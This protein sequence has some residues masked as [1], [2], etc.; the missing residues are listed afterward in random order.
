[1]DVTNTKGDWRE[2]TSDELL[3][4]KRCLI[5]HAGQPMKE[6]EPLQLT[7]GV[8]SGAETKLALHGLRARGW[9]EAVTKSWG[10]RIL[11][12]PIQRLPDLY[13]MLLEQ[14]TMNVV[15]T[16]YPVA[17]HEAITGLEAELLHT[18]SRIAVQGVPLT[19]KGTIHKRS[20]QK[21]NE[22]T[23][24]H[25]ED[26]V[27]LGL[28]YAHSDLYPVQT[29]IMMDLLLSLG[30][31]VKEAVSFRIQEAELAAWIQL[32]AW[33]MRKHI[34]N[35]LMER[36][37]KAEA[38]MQHFRYMLCAASR[39][40]GA[41][42]W[43][44]VKS[45][46]QWMLQVGL[47]SQERLNGAGSQ[48]SAPME[49]SA[50]P[51]SS[52]AFEDE[53]KGWLKALTAFGMGDWGLNALGELCFRWNISPL[54][55]LRQ[56][57]DEKEA[58]NQER[59]T[60]YIQPDFEILVPPEVAY[61]V[62]WRLECCCERVTGDR[63]AIYRIT[64]ESVTE[65]IELGMEAQAIFAL[66]DK[67]SRTGVPDHVRVALEQWA[68]DV[69]RTAFATVTLLRCGTHEDADTVA[70]HPGLEGLLERIGERD[71]IIPGHSTAKI[72]KTLAAIGLSPRREP[73]GVDEPIHRYP[74][75]D[76]TDHTSSG[77]PDSEIRP[78]EM[79]VNNDTAGSIFSQEGRAGLVYTGRTLHFYEREH[80]PPDPLDY[81]PESSAVP[82]SWT[83]EWRSYHVSTARQLI[84]QAIRW[85]T[86]VGLRIGGEE[87]KWIP[88][89]VIPGE[90]WSV[91][92]WYASGEDAKAP[93]RET[94]QPGEWSGMRLLVP[95]TL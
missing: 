42:G 29:A 95:F 14:S 2:L 10:E 30:L 73:E 59:G 61:D 66:L 47:I 54:D 3:V 16:D 64:R 55:M 37:G 58:G 78:N 1:M 84:E 19:A 75:V 49:F 87:V 52:E 72:R 8:L 79:T 4:L 60:F 93:I 26:L 68:G 9:M 48:T 85:Q 11:Y 20:L 17:V 27:G 80:T 67:Y 36:Y 45:L 6:E 7:T 22:L 25:P 50:G 91:M 46:L 76:E 21:L 92:G 41:E 34:F 13:D 53:I 77:S 56:Y 23:P 15:H 83:K 86:A 81:F 51:K 90:P 65:A 71:F 89:S 24:F 5:R 74:L 18:L 62:R 39:Y 57:K 94:L 63:M 70:R 12:I 28:Q 32:S 44:P 38:S 43:M 31:L 69:G 88:E 40:A 33:Q 35:T 82:S